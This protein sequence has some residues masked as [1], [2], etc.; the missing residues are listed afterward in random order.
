MTAKPW[1]TK[2][3]VSPSGNPWPTEAEAEAAMAPRPKPMGAPANSPAPDPTPSNPLAPV[4]LETSALEA[5]VI[6]LM[7]T[8][9][10]NA[11][12]NIVVIGMSDDGRVISLR[13]QG[14]NGSNPYCLIG[15][16]EAFKQVIIENELGQ[17]PVPAKDQS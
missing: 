9:T 16:L 11:C 1:E 13:R 2:P 7:G 17:T 6:S 10:Q 15:A 14:P 4:K 8:L 3:P 12:E 5:D